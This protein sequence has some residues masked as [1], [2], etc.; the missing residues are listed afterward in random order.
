[1]TAVFVEISDYNLAIG[2][3]VTGLTTKVTPI[4]G[5]SLSRVVLGWCALIGG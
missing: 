5:L 2:E 4:V 3:V 1:M